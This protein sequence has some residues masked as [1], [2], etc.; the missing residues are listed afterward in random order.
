MIDEFARWPK[1]DL[2]LLATCVE[3]L[4]WI[5]EVWMENHLVRDDNCNI[6]I[7]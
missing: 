3:I 2:L 1:P 7:H 5:N 4:S 6:V